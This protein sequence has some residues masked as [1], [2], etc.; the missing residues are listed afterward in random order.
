MNRSVGVAVSVL[1]LLA[2]PPFSQGQVQIKLAGVTREM[3]EKA[4]K[5]ELIS[6]DPSRS[7]DKPKDTFHGWKVLGRTVVK[8]A[9]TRKQLVAALRKG[10]EEN[11]RGGDAM[12]LANCFD[13]R[14][15]VRVTDG[16]KSVELVICFRCYQIQVYVDGFRLQGGL[17][18]TTKTQQA[19]FDQALQRARVPLAPRG[20]E[21]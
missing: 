9:E 7:A 16:D 18:P 8:D 12:T 4:E 6:L 17:M 19:V 20:G 2:F 13:P 3:L 21:K 11:T 14:H 5:F 15:G 10:I 1:G